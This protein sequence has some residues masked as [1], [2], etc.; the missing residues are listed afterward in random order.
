MQLPYRQPVV[1]PGT[2]STQACLL[3]RLCYLVATTP[4]HPTLGG[5]PADE[6]RSALGKIR[7]MEHDQLLGETKR[8]CEPDRAPSVDSTMS[9]I[10]RAR[11]RRVG[12]DEARG[13]GGTN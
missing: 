2:K 12:S 6:A 10:E 11:K 1:L 7:L 3:E 8:G 4:K 13:R 9:W 5:L